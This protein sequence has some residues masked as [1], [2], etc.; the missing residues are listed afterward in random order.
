MGPDFILIFHNSTIDLE[1]IILIHIFKCQDHSNLGS[2]YLNLNEANDSQYWLSSRWKPFRCYQV[3]PAELLYLD[4]KVQD[5]GA[6]CKCRIP[7]IIHADVSPLHFFKEQPVV[8]IVAKALM[9][10]R[11]T[12]PALCFSV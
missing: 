2:I 11:L 8:T 3:S 1:I 4:E 10:G 6:F 9:Q 12:N 5:S 7:A